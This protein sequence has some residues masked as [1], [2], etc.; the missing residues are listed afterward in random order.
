LKG[1]VSVNWIKTQ[2]LEYVQTQ[3]YT[4]GNEEVEP[5]WDTPIVGFSSGAD[6]LYQFYKEDIGDFYLTPNEI[7]T[8]HTNSPS[9]KAENVTVISWVLPHTEENKA[10]MRD[11]THFPTRR[12]VLAKNFGEQVNNQLREHLAQALNQE[13]I[14]AIAPLNSPLCQKA[15][16]DK[17]GRI[18]TWSE[19]HAAYTS[20]LG[21]FGLSDGLITPEGQAIRTGSIIAHIKLP[22]SPRPYNDHHQNCLYFTKGIC[23]KCIERCPIGAITRKGHDKELC[24]KYIDMI[25]KY[26]EKHYGLK[27]YACGFCQTRVPCESKIP[28]TDLE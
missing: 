14:N 28:T 22:T 11:Q 3:Q 24:R 16:S 5:L 21:T 9:I 26:V 15:T 10:G 12:W 8:H 4:L 27:G 23:G 19:R 20:G 1:L 18:R 2:I 25:R 17:Y 7:M 6:S 13:G